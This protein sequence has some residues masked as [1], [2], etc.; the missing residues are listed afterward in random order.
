M[1][2]KSVLYISFYYPPVGGVASIRAMKMSRYLPESGIEPVILTISPRGSRIPL[3][4]SLVREIPETIRIYRA[5]FPDMGWL[6]KILWGLKLSKWVNYI[7]QRLMIPGPEITWL[8]FAKRKIRL[9]LKNRPDIKLAYISS[10]PPAAL[11]MG[12]HLLQRYGIPY[13][14]E[15][16]DEWTNNPER[17]NTG[18][19]QKAQQAEQKLEQH[20]LGTCAG[21]VYL[22]NNMRENFAARY[23]MLNNKPGLVLPNG[24][25]S[26]DFTGLKPYAYSG[27]FTI[28]Y[29]GSFYDRRQ[30]D[31]LWK[32]IQ[33]LAQSSRIDPST[34]QIDIIG[35]NTPRF[36]LGNYWH[37][38]TINT[39]VNF[40][41]FM[42][43]A[44]SLSRL[45]GADALLLYIPSGENTDSVLT[46]KIFDYLYS[47]KP[48]LAIVPPTGLAA[49]LIKQAGV[50]FIADY[51]DIDG[52]SAR[53]MELYDLWRNRKLTE[54]RH[55]SQAYAAYSRQNLAR[56][57]ALFLSDILDK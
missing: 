21:C 48:I 41:G 52:I 19:S 29:S 25:D 38:S 30:P 14:C 46:G 8:P 55:N 11:L 45:M 36:V 23:P 51:T 54:I 27:K 10:G 22:T 16:R 49:D 9:I 2:V 17:V 4:Q 24:F 47:G 3:D 44:E 43:H 40:S 35:K 13:V 37:D 39:I 5:F 20:I 15:F 7:S 50:G 42:P 6:F 12:R 53:F 26:N 33:N 18:Y 56:Q 28:V 34:I 31:A 32:A 1:S 57:L